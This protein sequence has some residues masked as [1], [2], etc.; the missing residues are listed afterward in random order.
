MNVTVNVICSLWLEDNDGWEQTLDQPIV[1]T[2]NTTFVGSP[3]F[4]K[5]L[6]KKTPRATRCFELYSLYIGVLSVNIIANHERRL[7][8]LLNPNHKFDKG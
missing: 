5:E 8:G 1:Q 2:N 6:T 3:M 7:I 4:Y